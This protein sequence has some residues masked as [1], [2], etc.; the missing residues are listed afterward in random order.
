[1]RVVS[2]LD[3]VALEGVDVLGEQFALGVVA[4]LVR[5][6]RHGL[7]G[8]HRG[9]G[10]LKRA[11]DAGDGRVEQ[12]GDFAGLPFEDVAQDQDGTLLGRQVL[13]GGDKG[14]TDR[15][16]FGRSIGRIA[17]MG[18]HDV[19]RC[20]LD[21]GTLGQRRSD[22]PVSGTRHTRHLH[23]E[24]AALA[25]AQRIEAHVAGDS[26]QPGA[27][28]GTAFETVVG[29]PG[30]GEGLLHG[31]LSVEDRAQHPVTEPGELG[32]MGR[33][34]HVVDR[35]SGRRPGGPH[36]RKC[37][38]GRPVRERDS[39][40]AHCVPRPRR[41]LLATRSLALA[42]SQPRTLFD[43]THCV[44]RPRRPLLATRSLALARFATEDVVR[45]DAA[46]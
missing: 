2:D 9:V 4:Q 6:G 10:S 20:R 46:D 15:F 25:T 34:E 13:E 31:V 44:P 39:E 16:T 8:R 41:P 32:A 28:L 37:T 33:R 5:P 1:M 14:E 3:V 17:R 29:A 42:R 43:P 19:A 23:R 12:F 21:E 35:R 45:S 22:E 38:H 27:Y 11:V 26:I 18:G 40:H 30:P 7:L 36:L 24:G